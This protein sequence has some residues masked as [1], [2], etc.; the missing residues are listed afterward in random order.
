M[1][2][3]LH[4]G[5]VLQMSEPNG[6][7]TGGE[8]APE[9][10]KEPLLSMEEP[11][12]PVGEPNPPGTSSE[13][14]P[15][16]KQG[17]EE[18]LRNAPSLKMIH[19]VNTLAKSYVN[20]QKMVGV[21]K[22]PVPGKH[23]TAE[24]WKEVYTRLGLP[25]TLDNYEVELAPE[26][27]E[28]LKEDE[29]V[30]LKEVAYENNILPGQLSKILEYYH[31]AE[32]AQYAETQAQVEKQQEE[33]V[34]AL[35]KEWGLAF[36]AKTQL[37]SKVL[38]DN[39]DDSDW[40]FLKDTGLTNSPELARVMAKIGTKLYDESTIKDGGPGSMNG[41]LSPD[42]ALAEIGRLQGTKEYLD[43]NHPGHKQAVKDVQRLYKMAYPE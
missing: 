6:E 13:D 9:G 42:E 43:G 2:N 22:I 30:K 7:L 20:A 39:A 38:R 11:K 8:G 35:K 10:G 25:D 17:L 14:I 37:A 3:N 31:G 5:Y 34:A 1:L 28:N 21:D 19:D 4:K 32:K 26:L 29:L 24:D 41:R 33:A 18:E 12:E 36:E 23:A 27:K 16:W 15:E 40:Q